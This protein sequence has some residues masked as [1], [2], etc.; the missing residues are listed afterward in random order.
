MRSTIFVPVLATLAAA[1]SQYTTRSP[2]FHL[3]VFSTTNETINNTAL[4]ACHEGA[5]I[6]GFCRGPKLPDTSGYGTNFYFNTSSENTV[7]GAANIPGILS[8]DLVIAD[9]QT[10]PSSMNV[11]STLVSN[12]AV[13]VIY[14]GTSSAY[15]VYF[16]E[17]DELYVLSWRDDTVDPAVGKEER[18]KQWYICT[19][20]YSYTYVT[21]AWVIGKGVN[22]QNPTCQKVTVKRV[23]V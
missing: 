14:P 3:V 10:V 18:L 12:V 6:E 15:E 16:D 23:W 2:D 21:L 9:N 7:P 1:Q 13:P 11:A 17:A 5:A 4:V 19:T 8:Y 22:P 20:Y